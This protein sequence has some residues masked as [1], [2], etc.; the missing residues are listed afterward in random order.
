[1]VRFHQ[2]RGSSSPAY[3]SSFSGREI[4]ETFFILQTFSI[5][6]VPPQSLTALTPKSRPTAMLHRSHGNTSTNH[7]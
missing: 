1:M 3:T 4:E 6:S 2:F 5:F 7:R